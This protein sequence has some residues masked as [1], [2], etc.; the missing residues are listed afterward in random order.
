[1]CLEVQAD[2]K[3][4]LN[5]KGERCERETKLLTPMLSLSDVDP[6]AVLDTLVL[7][8]DDCLG[9]VGLE[10]ASGLEGIVEERLL[11]EGE[12]W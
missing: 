5:M 2:K 8:E 4:V 10:E 12:H 6:D 9:A 11:V 3:P 7:L 1:M